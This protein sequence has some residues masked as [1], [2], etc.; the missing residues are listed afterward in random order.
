METYARAIAKRLAPG[1]LFML[2][3]SHPRP[4]SSVGWDAAAR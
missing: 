3:A 2:Y 4:E 1:G